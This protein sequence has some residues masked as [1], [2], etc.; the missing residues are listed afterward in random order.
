MRPERHVTR[1]DSNSP[2]VAAVLLV[3]AI[4]AFPSLAHADP[5]G[6]EELRTL[7]LGATRELLSAIASGDWVPWERWLDP[8]VRYAADDGKIYSKD[9]LKRELRPLPPGFTGTLRP[10]RFEVRRHGAD[11]AITVHEDAEEE[12]VFGQKLHVRYRSTDTWVRKGGRWRLVASHVTRMEAD[13]PRTSVPPEVLA[14]YVGTYRLGPSL[15]Y[16]VSLEGHTLFG[17]RGGGER[18]E[19]VPETD[20]VF[21]VAGRPGRKLFLVEGGR[22]ARLLDRRDGQDLVWTRVE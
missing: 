6:D 11:V 12:D 10:E 18:V 9:E 1:D 7:L 17:Q 22:T 8:A 19:L 4:A 15:T 3:A 21:F 20:T 16:V 5:R 13:P 14:R 2:H